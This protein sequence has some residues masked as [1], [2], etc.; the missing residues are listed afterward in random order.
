MKSGNLNFLEPSGPLQACNWTALPLSTDPLGTGG[1]SL[2]ISGAHFGNQWLKVFNVHRNWVQTAQA[3]RSWLS[4]SGPFNFPPL[5]EPEV[6]LPYSGVPPLVLRFARWVHSLTFCFLKIS[7][8]IT[9]TY[10]SRATTSSLLS[11]AFLV[12]SY[13]L[14]DLPI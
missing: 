1:G 13:M 10:V 11:I 2:G 7:Y 12:Y 4:L 9:L 6:S 14:H 3:F 8:N 5:M